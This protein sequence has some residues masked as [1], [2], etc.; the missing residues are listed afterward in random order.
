MGL[1]WELWHKPKDGF[2]AE[3]AELHQEFYELCYDPDAD[4]ETSVARLEEI[5][6][7]LIDNGIDPGVTLGAPRIGPDKAANDW[8][9]AQREEALANQEDLSEEEMEHWSRPL[10]EI[11]AESEGM[12]VLD[13]TDYALSTVT[14]VVASPVSF[15]GGIVSQCEH[16]SQ[17]MRDQ[18]HCV[19]EADACVEYG[20]ALRAAAL[21]HVATVDEKLAEPDAALPRLK[22]LISQTEDFLAEEDYDALDAWQNDLTP[23]DQA[24]LEISGVLDGAAWLEFW[25]GLGHGMRPDF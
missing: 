23:A 8:L 7:Y 15:R 24:L 11:L 19:L 1:D 20:A 17:D 9:A 3:A 14:G 6:S 4:E 21:A 22:T 25:G 2:E 18:A 10:S 12:Y 5:D 13:L 16:L